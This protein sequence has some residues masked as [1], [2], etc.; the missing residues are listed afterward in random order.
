[1]SSVHHIDTARIGK[2]VALSKG[3]SLKVSRSHQEKQASTHCETQWLDE[4]DE[5]GILIARLRTW[6]NRDLSPPYRQQLG[7]ERYSLAGEMLIREI[8]Y[9]KR[10]NNDYV[11]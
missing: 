2:L 7:W 9:S 8:R 4:H 1:M 6:T 10:S 3:H 5:H 11:H